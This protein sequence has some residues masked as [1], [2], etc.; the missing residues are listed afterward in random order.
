MP[1]ASAFRSDELTRSSG[2][3]RGR[4]FARSS[5]LIKAPTMR[6]LARRRLAFTACGLLALALAS[7]AVGALTNRQSDAL[8]ERQTGPFSYFPSE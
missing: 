4:A 2:W 3:I 8:G 6:Q 5:V 1:D 7:G